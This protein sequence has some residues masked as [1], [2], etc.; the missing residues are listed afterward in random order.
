MINLEDWLEFLD[1]DYDFQ[2]GDVNVDAEQDTSAAKV[3]SC[4][5]VWVDVGFMHSK[6][7]CKHCDI[8]KSEWEKMQR[9]GE[10][11]CD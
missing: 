10:Q 1:F 4:S 8:E 3:T 11:D 5:H 6:V 7:V 9:Q 2:F